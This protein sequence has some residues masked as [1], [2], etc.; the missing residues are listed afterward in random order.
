MTAGKTSIDREN[1][2]DGKSDRR[3]RADA[4]RNTDAILQAAKAVFATAG[5][6][7][8]VRE[9]AAQAGVG[10]GTVYRSFPKRSDLIAAVFRR[11]VDNFAEAAE[12][13]SGQRAPAD[14]LSQWAQLYVDFLATKRGLGA[15]LYSGDPAYEAL[16]GY[17][18][19]RL[20]PVLKSLLERAIAAGEVRTDIAPYDLLRAVGNL[21]STSDS[22]GPE[23][24]RRMV[25]VLIDGLRF[26]A[27]ASPPIGEE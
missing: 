13:L 12:A 22:S 4:Q 11:E 26:G 9:I 15:A 8:P 19:G 16:P 5:V 27:N 10:I 25:A 23:H 21:A 17:F 20:E 6:A 2:P 18:R 24:A 1:K 3:T 7:A 14:A